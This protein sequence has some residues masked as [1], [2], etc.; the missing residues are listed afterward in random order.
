MDTATESS[1]GIPQELTH[2]I[3]SLALN[4]EAPTWSLRRTAA[5][6]TVTLFWSTSKSPAILE[7]RGV[8]CK[9]S[10][11]GKLK[12]ERPNYNP[13]KQSRQ[14]IS[15]NLQSGTPQHHS[16]SRARDSDKPANSEKPRK[17]RKSPATRARDAKRRADFLERKRA[18]GPSLD[19]PKETQD[20]TPVEVPQCPS[21]V[22]DAEVN[23]VMGSTGVQPDGEA[24]PALPGGDGL[25]LPRECG[26]VAGPIGEDSVDSDMD[27]ED[28]DDVMSAGC[29]YVECDVTDPDLLKKCT[30]CKMALYC[31]RVC[32]T[33]DWKMHKPCC[34]AVA[35]GSIK[36]GN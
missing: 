4:A 14:H 2:V 16:N 23:M 32:Q 27:F 10:A 6:V 25:V 33:K 19:A 28:S 29:C 18:H 20:L 24:L 11:P 8:N 17:K 13:W 12:L 26:A 31:S 9:Q 15:A 34:D 5:G 36:L 7:A 22:C 21:H 30:R 35:S 3:H 1:N